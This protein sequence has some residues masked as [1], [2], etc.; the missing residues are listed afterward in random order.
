MTKK[1]NPDPKK[2]LAE[3]AAFAA[4]RGRKAGSFLDP[5]AEVISRARTV[6]RMTYAT[7]ADYLARSGVQ[8]PRGGKLGKSHIEKFL[9]SRGLE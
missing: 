7:I 9:K 2:L 3:L 1:G 4:K 6:Q 8:T 5:Y